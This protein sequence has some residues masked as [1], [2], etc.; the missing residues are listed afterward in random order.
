MLSFPLLLT[1]S[2][3]RGI[4]KEGAQEARAPG[5]CASKPP[6]EGCPVGSPEICLEGAGHHLREKALEQVTWLGLSSL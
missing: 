1:P 5:A 4:E 3:A 6:Q 2:Q